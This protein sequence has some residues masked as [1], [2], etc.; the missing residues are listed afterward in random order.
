MSL[1]FTVPVHTTLYN[2]RN[3]VPN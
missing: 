2:Y 3:Q 1:L